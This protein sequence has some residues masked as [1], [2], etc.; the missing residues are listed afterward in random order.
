M[1]QDLLVELLHTLDGPQWRYSTL[2][3]YYTGRQPLSFLSPEARVALGDRFGRMASN[4]P[5]LAV[6]SLAER[7]RVVGFKGADVWPD[8]LRLD[9][10]QLSAAAHRD[11]LLFGQSFV[12]C[13]A[14]S[15]GRPLV[16]VESPKQVAVISDPGTR[17]VTSAVK[18]WRTQTTTEAVVYLPDQIIRLRADTP[19]AATAGFYVVETLDNPMGVVPVVPLRNSDLVSVWRPDANGTTDIGHS[20]LD[21]L[22][23]LVDGLNKVLTDLLVSSE[24]VGRPRRWATGIE[25]VERPVLDADGNPVLDNNNEPVMETV[26]PIPEGDRL[27]TAESEQAKFGQL[28]AADLRG[29]TNAVN[30]LVTQ[31]M[32]VSALPAHY[33]GILTDSPTSADAIRAAEASLTARAEARQQS[34]G[35]GWEQAARLMVAVR[36]GVD[37]AVVD[38]Q[39]QWAPADTRS[40]AAEADATVK[41]FQA[42]LL[43]ASYALQKLGY[44]ADEIAAIRAAR[45]ADAATLAN[46]GTNPAN[47]PQREAQGQK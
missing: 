10:D 46:H 32:A 24:Y 25:L 3:S 14:D 26:S 20:E 38:V 1:N 29:Y 35:R 45:T 8:W 18:R 36:D 22:M 43:P 28:D 21:D 23:P 5:R 16:T 13:W 47:G 9:L 41:L 15:V 31:I 12:I 6:T 27:M 11:A 40:V 7:L 33:V 34:F 44:S 30:V 37:P 17:A 2:Q 39:V 42:G 4:L 19:G